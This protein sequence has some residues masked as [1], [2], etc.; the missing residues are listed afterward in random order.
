[1]D[2]GT[3]EGQVPASVQRVF[4]EYQAQLEHA[5][6]AA[7]SEKEKERL[8]EIQDRLLNR[9]SFIKTDGETFWL[10]SE[11]FKYFSAPYIKERKE[12]LE[13]L[14]VFI[15]GEL[16]SYKHYDVETLEALGNQGDLRAWAT[17]SAL[18]TE[19]ADIDKLMETLDKAAVHGSAQAIASKAH[20][21]QMKL[22]SYFIGASELDKDALVSWVAHTEVAHRLGEPDILASTMRH[23]ERKD[24]LT[25]LAESDWQDINRSADSLFA[26]LEASREELG[27]GEFNTELP[28]HVIGYNQNRQDI[29]AL[30][31]AV[32]QLEAL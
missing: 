27:L 25:H 17:L 15:A 13:S 19:Q 22:N 23:L 29:R 1:M 11:H 4:D 21:Q 24:L 12:W 7:Q 18:Y 3:T 8:Q 16:D 6:K 14:G 26:E 28:D 31:E 10:D 9:F 20:F 30:R 32:R 2:T 5:E